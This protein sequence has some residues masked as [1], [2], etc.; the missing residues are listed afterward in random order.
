LLLSLLPLPL[1][2]AP[3]AAQTIPRNTVAAAL[4]DGGFVIVMRHANSPR[5]PPDAAMPVRWA[6]P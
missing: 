4:R 5:Q 2:A 1:T 3:L 6:R